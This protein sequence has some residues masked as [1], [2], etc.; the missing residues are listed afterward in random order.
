MCVFT[1]EGQLSAALDVGYH[2]FSAR[3][4]RAALVVDRAYNNCG[5]AGAKNIERKKTQEDC[6][7]GR[8]ISEDV[9]PCVR[10][11]G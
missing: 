2:N 6:V 9:D 4:S 5:V 3:D 7:M 8:R 10:L 1:F 11:E